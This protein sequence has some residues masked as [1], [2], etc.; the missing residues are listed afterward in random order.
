MREKPLAVG[1]SALV[2]VVIVRCRTPSLAAALGADTC[3]RLPW[4]TG[5][6]AAVAIG[7]SVVVASGEPH[8]DTPPRRGGA[9]VALLVVA[10]LST[11]FGRTRWVETGAAA[12]LRPRHGCRSS[13]NQ[14][15]EG[16]PPNASGLRE[17]KSNERSPNMQLRG[18]NKTTPAETEHE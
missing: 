1:A 7:T 13:G 2:I 4:A 8:L 10:V 3:R 9:P 11:T 15:N 18:D 5:A 14:T 17:K 16:A 12:E 6:V